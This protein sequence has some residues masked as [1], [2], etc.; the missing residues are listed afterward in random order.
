MEKEREQLLDLIRNKC[1][2]TSEEGF[3]LPSEQS[4]RGMMLIVLYRY[5]LYSLVKN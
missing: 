3:I 2:I 4:A 1:L 5:S